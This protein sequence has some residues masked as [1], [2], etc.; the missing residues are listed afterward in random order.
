MRRWGLGGAVVL[1]AVV[2][3]SFDP[4][5]PSDDD[6]GGTE[7]A[8][9]DWWNPAFSRRAPLTIV[10]ES[11][12]ALP[13]GFQIGFELT[14]TVG[15]VG[16]PD[17]V[18]IV[19][20]E[21][22][23]PR[24]IDTVGTSTWIWFALQGADLAPGATSH[25]YA[26]YCDN[27]TPSPAPADPKIVFTFHEDFDGPLDAAWQH[28]NVGMVNIKDGVL[29]MDARDS[30][31]LT[32]QTW[33]TGFAVDYMLQATSTKANDY[34]GGFQNTFVSAPPWDLWWT[35]GSTD[36]YAPSYADPRTD[37]PTVAID[38][39]PHVFTTELFGTETVWRY[40]ERFHHTMLHAQAG[41]FQ[42]RLHNA[43]DLYSNPVRVY[44]VRVRAA[45]NPA[46]VVTVDAADTMPCSK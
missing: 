22:E 10:N 38:L 2:G 16:L 27:P 7:D 23:L 9:C 19:N 11:T 21:V 43:S 44:W 35:L 37:G 41:P 39:L 46:P 6:P 18:R 31:I 26:L 25:D 33:G 32:V 8:T 5:I 3:C 30:S 40:D 15:C 14:P 24:V 29:T 28:Q 17:A 34:W 13:A 42:V 36:S 12:G 20:G 4:G 45:S 1:A